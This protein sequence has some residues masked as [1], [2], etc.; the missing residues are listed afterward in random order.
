M[1]SARYVQPMLVT[2]TLRITVLHYTYGCATLS[3]AY[4]GYF[5]LQNHWV[6]L[7]RWVSNLKCSLC[8]LG[9][10]LESLS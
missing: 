10:P 9:L 1:G 6:T 7:D 8:W 5:Y 4:V 3:A 2:F